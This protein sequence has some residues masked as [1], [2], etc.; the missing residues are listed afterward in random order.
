MGAYLHRSGL[1]IPSEAETQHVLFI[2]NKTYLF[3]SKFAFRTAPQQ[4][5]LNA[6]ICR[7]KHSH[8]GELTKTQVPRS[9]RMRY[10]RQVFIQKVCGRIINLNF[11]IPFSGNQIH[12]CQLRTDGLGSQVL[13]CE[14]F[15]MSEYAVFSSVLSRL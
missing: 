12:F 3:I 1:V 5:F 2:F 7:L 11:K 10:M 9:Q 14:C 15:R 6:I 13:E 4:C 8:L